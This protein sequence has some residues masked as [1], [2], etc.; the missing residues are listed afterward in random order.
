MVHTMLE[1]LSASS[2]RHS[3]PRCEAQQTSLHDGFWTDLYQTQ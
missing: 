1:Q 2:A 3:K